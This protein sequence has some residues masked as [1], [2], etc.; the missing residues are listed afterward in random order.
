MGS[1]LTSEKVSQVKRIKTLVA[2]V[3]GLSVMRGE[4]LQSDW[5][6]TGNDL[7]M[8]VFHVAP[9]IKSK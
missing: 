6:E 9:L 4:V 1:H 7:G 3:L 8:S 2:G 5:K